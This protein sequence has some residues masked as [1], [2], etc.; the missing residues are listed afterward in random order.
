MKMLLNHE[1]FAEGVKIEAL[2]KHPGEAED[3]PIL[4]LRIIVPTKETSKKNNQESIEFS[5]DISKDTPEVV[6]GKMVR[7]LSFLPPFLSPLL[8]SPFLPSPPPPFL[9]SFPPPPSMKSVALF[10]SPNRV[11][12]GVRDPLCSHLHLHSDQLYCVPCLLR[13]GNQFSWLHPEAG[14]RKG[15]L[16]LA[17]SLAW[18]CPSP[19]L[20]PPPFTPSPPSLPSC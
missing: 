12:C 8:P 15:W 18:C 1:F 2:P 5:Y 4:N 17:V 3:S 6:V 10:V 13:A 16:V 9:L 20:P 7:E 14:C 11:G 19:P